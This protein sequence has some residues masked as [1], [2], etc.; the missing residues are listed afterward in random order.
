M[1]ASAIILAT[2]ELA[3]VLASA[4]DA[5]GIASIIARDEYDA[6]HRI[7]SEGRELILLDLEL[8]G[9]AHA[10]RTVADESLAV[11][12]LALARS[13]D[14][15]A[16]LR[17]FAGGAHSCASRS[18]GPAELNARVD[19]LLRRPSATVAPSARVITIGD[20]T[21]DA[22]ARSVVV[23][24]EPVA[25]AAAKFDVLLALA[26]ERGGVVSHARLIEACR[27]SQVRATSLRGIMVDLRR[28]TGLPIRV[29]PRVG[30]VLP[31]D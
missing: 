20:V 4:L 12:V 13:D 27:W 1:V 11:T 26:R 3:P 30:Y 17:A 10:L 31:I 16:T 14:A 7:R 28:L 15:D 6:M 2:S 25:L 29:I 19:A 22:A 5:N 8:P 18:C 24:G 23:A 21:I 9:A